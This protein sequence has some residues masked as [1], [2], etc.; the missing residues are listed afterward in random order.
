M[1]VEVAF[2]L[3]SRDLLNLKYT[4]FERFFMDS[5]NLYRIKYESVCCDMQVIADRLRHLASPLNA[6]KF[7]ID[8]L[9]ED[10]GGEFRER[11]EN[12]GKAADKCL[13][14]AND[15]LALTV[16]YFDSEIKR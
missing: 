7:Y 10:A 2:I 14:A 11:L 4:R 3:D 5:E 15:L 6:V 16:P 12:A 13:S 1:M 8:D 9:L